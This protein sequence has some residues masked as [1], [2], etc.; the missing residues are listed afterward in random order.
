MSQPSQAPETVRCEITGK[1]LPAVDTTELFGKRVGAEGKAILLDRV[2]S[3]R[4]LDLIL[5]LPGLKTRLASAVAD[6]VFPVILLAVVVPMF[7]RRF[8][9]NTTLSVF[10]H[11]DQSLLMSAIAPIYV[12]LIT[13]YCRGQSPSKNSYML[14]VVGAKG[15]LTTASIVMRTAMIMLGVWAIS[16]LGLSAKIHFQSAS[17]GLVLALIAMALVTLVIADWGWLALHKSGQTLH[18]YLAGT[19]VVK[20][21]HLEWR[22]LNADQLGWSGAWEN[23]KAVCPSCRNE[24]A[25]HMN[26]PAVDARHPTQNDVTCNSCDW[27]G[28]VILF[29]P[30]PVDTLPA[31]DAQPE[32]AVC[33]EHP[34]KRAGITCAKSGDYCCSLCAVI[35]DRVPLST[36]YLRAHPDEHAKLWPK[37][38]AADAA[39]LIIGR[40]FVAVPS[41][42]SNKQRIENRLPFDKIEAMMIWTEKRKLKEPAFGAILLSV[43][44]GLPFFL[45]SPI[46]V[47]M[48]IVLAIQGLI[49]IIRFARTKTTF[50]IVRGDENFDY[51]PPKDAELFAESLATSIWRYQQV[52]IRDWFERFPDDPRKPRVS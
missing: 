43:G 13:L 34:T 14:K 8:G 37:L 32:D 38:D 1:E 49:R 40:D 27:R 31:P 17:D 35:V 48:G 15:E 20:T 50:R 51:S 28:K 12:G 23:A 10:N 18:D 44:A 39:S 4:P 19:R 9:I 29:R 22:W 24:L 33:T 25:L 6:M 21:E 45:G 11:I 41:I 52:A 36:G 47:V 7:L 3:R 26:G 30:T 5:P 46:T 16:F 42:K 2:R